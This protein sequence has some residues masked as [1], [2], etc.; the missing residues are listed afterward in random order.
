MTE[1]SITT[2]RPS[3][4][5]EAFQ[6]TVARFPDRV[7]LRTVGGAVEITWAEYAQR[8]ANVAAALASCGVRHGDT[9][10]MMLTNRPEAFIVD[11]AALHLGATPVSIYNTSSVEQIEYLLGHAESRVAVVEA[12]FADRLQ[13]ARA[14]LPQL[15]HVFVLDGEVEGTR[16]YSELEAGGEERF[17]LDAAWR[18]VSPDDVAALIYTSGTTGPPKGVELTHSNLISEWFCYVEAIP[19]SDGGRFVSYLPMAHLADRSSSHYPAIITA[20]TVT[21]VPN[22]AD[23]I[24]AAAE[25]R[26]TQ[27]VAVPR[28]WEKLKAALEAGFAAEPEDRRAAIT[29]AVDAAVQKVRLEMSGQPVP[30]ELAEACTRADAAIFAPLREKLGL[31][32]VE[33]LISG[34]APIAPEV[35]EFFTGLG[36]QITEGWGMSESAAA[37]AIN[38][39]G[40]IRIGTCGPPLPGVEMRLAEDGELLVRGP[41]VMR[42]YRKDP[43]KTAEAID[44]DGWLHTGDVCE[45]DADGYLRIVDRKK[46]LIINSAGKNMSPANIENALKASCPLIGVPVTIGDGRKYNTALIVL[47]PEASASFARDHG[48]TDASPAALA[49][50]ERVH[51]EVAAGVERA[52]DRL[53]RVEQIK[54]FTIL[55]VDWLPGGDELTHTMKLRRKPIAEKYAAEIEAMY[56]G[57]K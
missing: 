21:C 6:T 33:S 53:S 4:L 1:P 48:I 50:D 41:F 12:A 40:S 2:T 18:A 9:V 25:V 10:A 29:A 16:P 19:V 8:V 26:P 23:V 32:Q 37:G 13:Q 47:E 7:A 46:E 39:R 49:K 30:A 17:D 56:R 24:A 55:P 22:P 11:V 35:L 28:I 5:C 51:A 15:E 44:P 38:R 14:A 31:D 43:V 45:F 36:V 54:K 52:N 34:G 42:G 20:G 3:T 27:W 57:L